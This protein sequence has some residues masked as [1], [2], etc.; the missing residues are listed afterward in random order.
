MELA[1][2][3]LFTSSVQRILSCCAAFIAAPIFL[4]STVETAAA[5]SPET[6]HASELTLNEMLRRVLDHNESVQIKMLEAEISEKLEQAEQGIFEPQVVGSVEKSDSQRPNNTQQQL[7]LG[8]SPV[9]Q[10][11]ERNALYSGGLEFLLP[12]GGQLQTGYTL[13]KL[14]NNLQQSARNEYE[15]FVGTTLTQPLLKNFGRA[16]TMVRIRLAAL[17]SDIAFQEY[18][19]QLMLVFAG[20]EAAYWDLYLSQEQRR[21]TQ[22]SVA[23]AGKILKDNRERF[24]VGT[25]PELEVLQA[26]AGLSLRQTA[27]NEAQLK[28]FDG[29]N[30]LAT[31]YSDVT[32]RI[33]TPVHVTDHPTVKNVSLEY[34]DN[35]QIAYELNPDYLIGQTQISQE[36][37]RVQYARNQRLPQLNLSGSYGFNG[38]G[39]SPRDSH[40]DIYNREFP[41]WSVGLD[42][43]IPLAGGMK[44]RREWEAAKLGKTRA[45][46]GLREIE[47]QIANSLKSALL[48]VETYLENVQSYQ[49]VVDFHQE[50]FEAQL[51]RLEVGSIDSRTV[52]ETEEQLFQAK[53]NAVESLVSYRKALLELELIRGSTLHSRNLD[54]TKAQLEAKTTHLLRSGHW[55]DLTLES[56]QRQA[57]RHLDPDSQAQEE[58]LRIL[59][60][61]L[62]DSRS[63]RHSQP[64]R[65]D[66]DPAKE[67]EAA[68]SMRQKLQ[69]LN[70]RPNQN[71]S[72]VTPD[73]AAQHEAV[74]ALRRVLEKTRRTESSKAD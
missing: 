46:F 10:L 38:L 59:R 55:S 4:F 22:E 34:F 11:T 43:R 19:R 50:L 62:E 33:D 32:V 21:I 63:N 17:A 16:A 71:S 58:A 42:M 6:I 52:L 7:N 31:F 24:Q 64:I 13:R 12:S 23:M 2:Q 65:V 60:Q 47:V 40:G 8:F 30:R 1:I 72:Q 18:R 41:A 69:Q 44:E 28:V 5:E 54:L 36:E 56:Y 20:A 39:N 3:V 74:Q 29:A 48:K 26:Q 45:L 66:S 67:H 9:S 73:S 61:K 27:L 15:T 51:A 70:T 49:T 57:M 14:D 68:R 53:V 37:L 25:A 35:Y